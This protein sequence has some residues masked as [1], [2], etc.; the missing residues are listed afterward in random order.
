VP[1]SPDGN[2]VSNSVLARVMGRNPDILRAFGRLDTTIRFKGRLPMALKE[3]VRDATASRTG[4]AYCASISSGPR[5]DADDRRV[6]L[7]VAFA[8]LVA[9]DPAGID[10]ASFDVLREDFDDDEILE[11]VA[12]ICL[13]AI[14]GQLF[15]AVMK[16]EAASPEEAAAYQQVLSDYARPAP[17][18]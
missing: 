15:G 11:L 7:A 18:S 9:D 8:E 4:C 10:D 1:P 17:R 14:P 13:V 16:L 6:S 3:A 5:P 12:W 2:A